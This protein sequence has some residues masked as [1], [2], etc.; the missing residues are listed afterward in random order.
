MSTTASVPADAATQALG[1]GLRKNYLGFFETVAQSVGTI[2]PSGT[3]GLVIPV[4]FATAGNGTWLAYL[5]ATIALAIVGIQINVF[6]KRVA[7]P[8]S[9][10]VYAGLG[11]GPLAGVIA[12]WAL[13]IGYVFTAAAVI[14]GTV[15][16]GLALIRLAGAEVTG[17]GALIALS[18]I[19]LVVAWWFAYR[20]IKLS[21]RV[22]L[23]I[24]F[25]TLFLILLIVA[26][27][28]WHRGA[29]ADV[30]QTGLQGV[31]IDHLRLGLV[32]AFFSFVGFESATVLGRE[33]REPQRYIP[34]A[35]IASV[36]GVGLVFIV[37][38]YGLVAGFHGVDPSLD[39]SDAPLSV[40]AQ[41]F[42]GGALG[43]LVSAGVTL[44]FFACILGSVNAGARVLYSLSH[45]GLFHSR[46]RS[47]HVEHASPHVAA[48]IVSIV[49]LVLALALTLWGYAI[50]DAYGILGSIATYGFLVAYGMVTIGAPV[51]LGRRRE[52][53]PGHVISA[54]VALVLLGLTLFGTV[55]PVPAWPYNI[56]P[57]VFLA[58]L[59]VGIGYFL[60][61]RVFRPDRLA[62]IEADLIGTDGAP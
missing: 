40:L 8:G 62:R 46:A 61:L 7:T 6:A 9:L 29:V 37:S 5:F 54:L 55:Y 38:A 26:L 47:T 31:E 36:V 25:L 56:L 15:S 17:L 30:E 28:F 16:T 44:S 53:R 24:E 18:V 50:L 3:P 20:D 32:L 2:A 11:L 35:V 58:L 60:A 43:V 14:D 4:V 51:F 1:R 19:A 39:K 10:Y 27:F 52:L 41:S 42:G 21:T 45:H 23:G 33:S 13:V 22:T 48:T 34:R 12:G 49:A 59:V 57:Y